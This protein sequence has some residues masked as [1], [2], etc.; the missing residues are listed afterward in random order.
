MRCELKQLGIFITYIAKIL[1]AD[2]RSVDKHMKQL[3]FY[4]MLI[5]NRSFWKTK[6]V[7]KQ[8]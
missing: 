3:E 8:K 6:L 5:T 7:Q 4:T 2:I 1:K